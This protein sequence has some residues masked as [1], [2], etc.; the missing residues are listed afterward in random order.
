MDALFASVLLIRIHK[1]AHE[2]PVFCSKRTGADLY[3]RKEKQSK[4]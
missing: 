4:I 2:N 1:T 3:Y